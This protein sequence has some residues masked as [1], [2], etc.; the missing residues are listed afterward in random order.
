[1]LIFRDARW[2]ANLLIPALLLATGWQAHAVQWT[3]SQAGPSTWTYTL[4]FAPEDNYSIYQANT[5]ITMTG[6]T[7]VTAAAGP[8]STDF[9]SGLQSLELAWTAQVTN[10]GT[11][12]AWT[13]VGSGTGNFPTT[14]HVFGFSI[15]AAGALNG[16]V[17]YA[18]SGMSRDVGNPL[19][20]GGYNLDISGTVGGPSST[21][22][23][24]SAPALSPMALLLTSLGLALAGGY[25]VRS[26]LADRLR[27]D[28]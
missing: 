10:G 19:P 13:H 8:T 14:Q 11:T 20:G 24:A 4:T 26:R 17:S 21:G 6:L 1:M 2:R 15:T 23:P 18:T 25:Q 28:A 22:S 12:V 7:G 16:T 3:L 9:P 27:N 5:T